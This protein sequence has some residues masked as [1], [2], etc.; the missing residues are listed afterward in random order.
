MNRIFL[1]LMLTAAVGVALRAAAPA[2]AQE[3]F[4]VMPPGAIVDG[5]LEDDITAQ[6]FAFN[7][8]AGDNIT[9]DVAPDSS[10]F[11]PYAVLL[12]PAGGVLAAGQPPLSAVTPFSASYFVMVT[13]REAVNELQLESFEEPQGFQIAVNGNNPPPQAGGRLGYF[14]TPLPY[15][16]TF[17][18]GYSS[19][20]EAV[21][22]FSFDGERGDTLNIVATSTKIDPVIYLFDPN[23][24]RIE[25]ND[26]ADTLMLPATTDAAIEGFQVPQANTYHVFVTAVDFFDIYDQNQLAARNDDIEP[27]EYGGG[28]F[29]IY[30]ESQ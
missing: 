16:T 9:V 27:E 12:G 17:E 19:P 22:Y 23:G 7:A 14:V 11:V 5:T 21:Y 28:G 3:T 18:E 4:T 30:I 24:N 10:A 25:T 26:D 2:N 8:S 13:T 1:S 29:E 20:Q 6:L 15:N